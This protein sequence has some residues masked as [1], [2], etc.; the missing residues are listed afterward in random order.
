M[1]FIFRAVALSLV[2]R[3]VAF[4]LEW[5]QQ[6][7]HQF[8]LISAPR[9]G[10]PGFTRLAPAATGITFTNVLSDARGISNQ[11]YMSGSGV[12]AGDVDNDG[13]CDLYF[14]GLDSPNTLYRNLGNW[15]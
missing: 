8:A 5:Q 13:L 7:P 12:A 11:V 14:C 15:R 6:G 9:T 2:L 10:Q 4:G 3:A 1:R